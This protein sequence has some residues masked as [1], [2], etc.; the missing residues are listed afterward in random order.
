LPKND[1]GD[2]PELK[3]DEW[4]MMPP[5]QDGLAARMDPTKIRPGKFRSGKAAGAP[6]G[7]DVDSIWTETPEQKRKRLANEVLGIVAPAASGV[8]GKKPGSKVDE[9]AARKIREYNVCLID[10]S[11][12]RYTFL[13]LHRKNIE[14]SLCMKTTK[15]RSRKK[16]KM[17]PVS[18]RSIERRMLAEG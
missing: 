17:T 18:A 8:T 13:T 10:S 11:Y 16:R 2:E 4:M 3:R 6:A 9:E 14:A 15:R 5:T 1:K 7:G 12:S